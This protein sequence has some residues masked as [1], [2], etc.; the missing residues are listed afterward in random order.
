VASVRLASPDARVRYEKGG[1]SSADPGQITYANVTP[2]L[3]II[4]AFRARP[5]EI[6]GPDW[7]DNVGY[8]IAAKI[9][10]GTTEQRLQL[11]LQKLMEERLGMRIHREAKPLPVY[12]LV[13]GKGQPKVQPAKDSENIGCRIVSNGGRIDWSSEIRVE[14]RNT[15]MAALAEQMP[16]F[17]K[18]NRR[19]VDDTHLDG[20]YDFDLRWTPAPPQSGPGS[21][22]VELQSKG[23]LFDA[24]EKQVGLR[25][26]DRK[27]PVETIVVDQIN[28]APVEN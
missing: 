20:T 3:L 19:F 5:N 4:R 12:A 28:K 15:T 23:A 22:L 2:K 16:F 8:D 7:M 11:M 24:L 21:K 14:C 1:P 6:S 10:P 27:A 17:A 26:D 13:A 9:P 25:I 18:V